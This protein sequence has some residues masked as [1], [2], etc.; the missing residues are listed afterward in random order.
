M[1]KKSCQPHLLYI[2]FVSPY[3]DTLQPP[4]LR[5]GFECFFPLI[6]YNN[7]RIFLFFFIRDVKIEKGE[8]AN[9]LDA[10]A[11]VLLRTFCFVLKGILTRDF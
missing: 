1:P 5:K 10:A 6:V 7:V 8:D 3:Q 4:L 11:K 9:V 2:Q